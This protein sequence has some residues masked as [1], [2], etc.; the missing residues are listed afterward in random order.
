[1]MSAIPGSGH[2]LSPLQI[3]RVSRPTW[4]TAIAIF[5]LLGG[6]VNIYFGWSA[7]S[8][9]FNLLQYLDRPSLDPWFRMAVPAEIALNVAAVI[10]GLVQLITIF[11]LWTAKPWS[12]RLAFIVPVV[13][14]SISWGAVLLYLSAPAYLELNSWVN[15]PSAVMNTVW[16]GIFWGYLRR[17]R[18]KRYLRV[19]G[20]VPIA[21]GYGMA[22]ALGAELGRVRV[23]DLKEGE[24]VDFQVMEGGFTM[25][26]NGVMED[27]IRYDYIEAVY[28]N[29]HWINRSMDIR[30]KKG[31]RSFG[32][33]KENYEELLNLLSRVEAIKD[34]LQVQQTAPEED[35]FLADDK[36]DIT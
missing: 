19:D 30:L 27:V 22:P 21:G 28:L 10:L 17:P 33:D 24:R 4:L 5:W 7:A 8:S 29:V 13:I 20:G 9:D 11:G 18:V 26:I 23:A 1:M 31:E 16:I 25:S 2:S 32:L 15:V 34:R 12:Y 14:A 35:S 6:I 3:G 36:E